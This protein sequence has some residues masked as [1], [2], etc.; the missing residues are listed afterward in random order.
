[1]VFLKLLLYHTCQIL[2]AVCGNVYMV[3]E[4]RFRCHFATIGL[5]IIQPHMVRILLY[6]HKYYSIAI[7]I[8]YVYVLLNRRS[9]FGHHYEIHY[10]DRQFFI[11]V[12]ICFIRF[13]IRFVICFIIRLFI[14]L[15]FRQT[16]FK[17]L[18]AV[19]VIEPIIV[20]FFVFFVFFGF[21]VFFVFFV[22]IVFIAEILI[23]F[24]IR[25]TAGSVFRP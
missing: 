4:H 10:I 13:I 23:V 25:H 16:T 21:I 15:I 6:Q 19:F 2:C 11:T 12:N 14:H 22:F 1:M 3:K 5:H 7:P 9:I 20:I 18:K 8:D 17:I 24:I